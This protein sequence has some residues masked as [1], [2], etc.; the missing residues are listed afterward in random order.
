[1]LILAISNHIPHFPKMSSILLFAALLLIPR[2]SGFAD[3]LGPWWPFKQT[4]LRDQ[5]FLLLYQPPLIYSQRLCSFILPLPEPWAVPS[6][7][8]L[9]L[10]FPQL[11]LLVLIHCTLMWDHQVHVL[12]LPRCHLHHRLTTL[13]CVLSTPPICVDECF[14]FKSLVV[15][16]PYS[17]IFWQLWLVLYFFRSVVILLMVLQGGEVNLP[18]PSSFQESS[19]HIFKIRK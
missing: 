15:R 3:V 8:G 14:F 13:H 7:L 11:F 4:L 1:M 17:L 19:I 5:Q 6:G 12:Q 18:M 16:L 10:L 9:G 2:V